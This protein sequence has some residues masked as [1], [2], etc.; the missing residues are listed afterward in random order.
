[1]P[2]PNAP[3][4]KPSAVDKFVE[5]SPVTGDDRYEVRLAEGSIVPMSQMALRDLALKLK[6]LGAIDVR[7]LLE[8][9]GVPDADEIAEAVENEMKLAALAKVTRK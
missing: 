8:W 1:M 5:W 4:K 9:L 3:L 2:Q 6:Q 7:H